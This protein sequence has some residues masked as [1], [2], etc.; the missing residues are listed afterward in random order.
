[1]SKLL[2]TLVI[3]G[4]AGIISSFAAAPAI[5]R[6]WDDHYHIERRC[7]HDGDRCALFRCDRD[8]DHCTRVSSWRRRGGDWDDRSAY[9]GYRNDDRGGFYTRRCDR[10]GDRCVV[11]RCDR[12]GDRCV[13]VR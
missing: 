6:D 3:V 12:D 2:A 11:V 5:A 4:C 10:D 9:N 13:A 8:R 1:M 7:D